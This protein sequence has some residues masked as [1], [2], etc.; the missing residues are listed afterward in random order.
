MF[1]FSRDVVLVTGAA[2]GIGLEIASAFYRA[3]ARVGLGDFR[4]DALARVASRFDDASWVY[5]GPVDVRD[6]RS[7]EGFVNAVEAALGPITVGIACAGIYPNTLVLDMG[8]DEWDQVMETNARGV[9]LTCQAVARRMVAHG[10]SGKIVT[11]SSTAYQSGRVGAAHYCASKAAVAMFTRVLALELAPHGIN[12]NAIAP[13]MVEVEGGT[14]SISKEYAKAMTKVIPKGRAGQPI[15]VANAAMFLASPLAEF[16]TGDVL[17]V[18]G[19][20]SIGR[21]NLPRSTP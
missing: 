13:G 16:I 17:L 14:S 1:D 18:D 10:I 19:G 6:A 4:P 20:M 3:G 2:A 15:D 11:I 12:A 9:F 5:L 8:V 21:A 7:M